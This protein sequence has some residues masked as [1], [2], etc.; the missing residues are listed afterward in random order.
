VPVFVDTNVLVYA[1]DASAPRKQARASAWLQHLW[2]EQEGRL[3]IQVLQEYYITVTRKLRPAMDRADARRD[4]L[5]LCTWRPV[6]L[7][8]EM[9]EDA[10]VGEDRWGL[11]M[12]DAT[13]VAAARASGCRH[14]LT[15]DLQAGMDLDGVTI[16]DPFATEPA[17]LG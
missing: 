11:S 5:A 4:V 13:I 12:W 14:L 7:D 17:T 9:L 1:R 6:Y 8:E 2:R 15:E 10:F 16:V 3:S